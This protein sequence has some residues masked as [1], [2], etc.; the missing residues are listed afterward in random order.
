M[1]RATFARVRDFVPPALR[2]AYLATE[3]MVEQGDRTY[4]V[5]EL[6]SSAASLFVL[7][8]HNPRST[9]L[10]AAENADRN[11]EL[12][13]ALIHEGYTFW[14]AT[15]FD[16]SSGWA[17]ESFVLDELDHDSARAFCRD[18]EQYAYFEITNDEQIVHGVYSRW[19]LARTHGAASLPVS[20]RTFADAVSD[21]TGAEISN[22][23][24]RFRYP[25]WQLVS[26]APERCGSCGADPDLYCLTHRQRSGDVVEHL[27]VCCGQ[28]GWAAAATQL[29]KD[30]LRLLELWFDYQIALA[31]NGTGRKARRCYVVDLDM[32]AGPALYVGETGKPTEKRFR[33]H[34]DGYKAS[35]DVRR[36]GTGLNTELMQGLPEFPDVMTAR[37]YEVYLGKKLQLAGYTIRGAH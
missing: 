18:F 17:E 8:A 15:A 23:L 10:S 22:S 35:S 24:K 14:C 2:Y 26:P 7:T 32:P 13:E 28:C 12:E 5:D 27:A 3:I 11:T 34:V 37:T 16:P 9:Q 6:N 21:A 31:D 29:G 36:Y 19:S 25:G 1:A 20:R 33:E 4:P 30:R